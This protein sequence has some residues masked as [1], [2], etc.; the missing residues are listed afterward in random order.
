MTP[1][2]KLNL[3]KL[4]AKSLAKRFDV[5][6]R[7]L[8]PSEIQVWGSNVLPELAPA[9]SRYLRMDVAVYPDQAILSPRRRPS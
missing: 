4:Q 2:G 6:T 1:A 9:M 8:E 7:V 5:K 3:L